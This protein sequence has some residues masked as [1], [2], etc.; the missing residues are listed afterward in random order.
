MS[1]VVTIPFVFDDKSKIKL[2]EEGTL[3]MYARAKLG[4]R[5]TLYNN[6]MG[7]FIFI[8]GKVKCTVLEST[9][10]PSTVIASTPASARTDKIQNKQEGQNKHENE[11]K[12][13]ESLRTLSAACESYRADQNPVTYPP[14]LSALAEA[15]PPYIDSQLGSG[16]KKGYK[17][18]YTRISANQY[19]C[20]A[21][22]E[23]PGVMGDRTFFIDESGVIRLDNANGNPLE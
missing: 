2:S 3:E 8:K 23:E 9:L 14:D 19:T 10:G 22:P 21:K 17:Y 15:N 13:I 18:I 1:Y 7:W 11:G 12:A 4:P 5:A 16:E 6:P 20:F